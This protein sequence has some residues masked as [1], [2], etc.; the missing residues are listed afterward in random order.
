MFNSFLV[1]KKRLLLTQNI[2][3]IYIQKNFLRHEK[4]CTALYLMNLLFGKIVH[5]ISFLIQS[6]SISVKIVTF[7]LIIK[8]GDQHTI[9]LYNIRWQEG[10]IRRYAYFCIEIAGLPKRFNL[11]LNFS[12]FF[13]VFAAFTML[14]PDVDIQFIY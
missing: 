6:I 1:L 2:I 8:Q 10:Y 9:L 4:Q 12:F 14:L 11:Y 5:F 13:V 3:F 7:F